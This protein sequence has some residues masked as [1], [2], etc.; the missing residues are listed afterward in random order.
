MNK[1]RTQ[2][3]TLIVYWKGESKIIG[4]IDY[5][6]TFSSLCPKCGIDILKEF[7]IFKFLKDLRTTYRGESCSFFRFHLKN[8]RN[9]QMTNEPE[10]VSS[11]PPPPI[12]HLLFCDQSSKL[13][14]PQPPSIPTDTYIMFGKP[15]A[16][17]TQKLSLMC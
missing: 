13:T 8:S 3:N 16:V 17:G 12:Y 10:I 14:P 1:F 5:R 4:E 7:L 11:F 15:Y 9:F 6:Y 2:S